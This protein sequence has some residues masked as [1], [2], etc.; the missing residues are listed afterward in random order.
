MNLK[1]IDSRNSREYAGALKS[2]IAIGQPIK[3]LL[4]NGT[5]EFHISSIRRCLTVGNKYYVV[6]NQGIRFTLIFQ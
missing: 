2:S 5:H 4:S 1:L 3:I 6:D